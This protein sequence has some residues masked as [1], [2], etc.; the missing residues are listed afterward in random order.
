MACDGG[1]L[2]DNWGIVAILVATHAQ[3]CASMLRVRNWCRTWLTDRRGGWH[4]A[5]VGIST[6]IG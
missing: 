3:E 2:G 4:E 5:S 1:V 6:V